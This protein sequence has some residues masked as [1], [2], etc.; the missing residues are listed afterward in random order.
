MVEFALTLPMLL[1]LLLGVAD[2][3]RVFSQGI[4]LE[5]A[6][7]NGAEAAAQE[8]VQLQRNRPGGVLGTGDYAAL[9][10]V[11]LE[12][13]CE[14]A[15]PLPNRIASGTPPICSMPHTAVCVHDAVQGDA[16]ANGGTCGG[17][18]A[19]APAKCT[20]MDPTWTAAIE[21]TDPPT[22]LPYVELRV[23]YQFT[24]LFNLTDVD[25]PFGWSL[26][27]GD[28]WLQRDRVFV[29]GTY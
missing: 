4:I 12:A 11:A 13:V 20:I 19:A 5:A 17:E 14:E 1:I 9:H 28:F 15:D 26:S 24:T 29:A 22:P 8:Y 16:P 27:I 2:F 21:Q 23:C 3:G 25:L 6:A 18:A 10:T 7:R